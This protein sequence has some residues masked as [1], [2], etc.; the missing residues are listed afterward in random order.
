VTEQISPQPEVS[1]P[2]D[3]GRAK[4]V[5]SGV[6][7]TLASFFSTAI[8]SVKLEYLKSLKKNW[9]T[10]KV[11]ESCG[12]LIGVSPT[13][14]TVLY[15]AAAAF[16]PDELKKI[17]ALTP[18]NLTLLFNP[19]DLCAIIGLVY[20]HR[21]LKKHFDPTGWRRVEEDAFTAMLIASAVGETVQHMSRGDA[22]LQGGLRV[23][24]Q[25]ALNT[26]GKDLPPITKTPLAAKARNKQSSPEQREVTRYGC[27]HLQVTAQIAQTLGFGSD[28]GSCIAASSSSLPDYLKPRAAAW[29]ATRTI[30][31]SFQ[32]FGHAPEVTED[33]ELYLSSEENESLTVMVN[34]LLDV[35]LP[36]YWISAKPEDLP[37][38][39]REALQLDVKQAKKSDSLE[40]EI[41][42]DAVVAVPP[43]TKSE[44]EKV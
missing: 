37:P 27:S 21:S 13:L 25:A 36:K 23:L 7:A 22:M 1:A 19:D 20:T 33:S 29:A 18:K 17:S 26:F 8:R 9:N 4:I 38:E 12:F 39:I 11:W 14:K 28:I 2:D 5:A 31:D 43:E 44:P 34:K 16:Y 30:S 40:D 6:T 24:A 35:E 15:H 41:P 32:A 10:E 42:A 3:F